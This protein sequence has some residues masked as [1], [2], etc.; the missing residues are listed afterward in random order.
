MLYLQNWSYLW[1]KYNSLIF[2]SYN[3]KSSFLY[4]NKCKKNI[5]IFSK[6]NTC[7]LIKNYI[8]K[9][10]SSLS[11][12][13]LKIGKFRLRCTTCHFSKNAQIFTVIFIGHRP[14]DNTFFH[15][16]HYCCIPFGFF[17]SRRISVKCR[18]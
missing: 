10:C 18:I 8:S 2:W 5:N 15:L 1:I 9:S 16:L 17:I 12:K 3:S 4:Q 11:K 14:L 13:N 6:F 7:T